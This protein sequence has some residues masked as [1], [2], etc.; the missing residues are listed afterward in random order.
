MHWLNRLI[1]RIAETFGLDPASRIGG[2]IQF[3]FYDVIKIFVLLG[4]EKVMEYGIMTMPA[5]VVNETVV[6]AG[7]VLKTAEVEKLL[8]R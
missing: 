5:I 7:K 2:S 8:K 1:G 4:M 6:S 3:F